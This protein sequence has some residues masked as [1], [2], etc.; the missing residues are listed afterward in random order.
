[1]RVLLKISQ[2]KKDQSGGASMQ[3]ALLFGAVTLALTVLVTPQLKK[4]GDYYAE[5]KS[6]GIDRVITGAIEKNS[7]RKIT[8]IRKSVLDKNTIEF[9]Q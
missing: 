4:A 2:F 9:S 7:K 6:L 1:M 5:N 8:I 3:A